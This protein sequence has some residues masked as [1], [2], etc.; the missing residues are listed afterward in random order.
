MKNVIL[1]TAEACHLCELALE[2]IEQSASFEKVLLTEIDINSDMALLKEFATR[3]PVLTVVGSQAHLFWPFDHY[4][5]T[6]W[7]ESATPE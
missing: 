2:Q 6:Q 5:V 1:Y 4:D 3:V 7:L